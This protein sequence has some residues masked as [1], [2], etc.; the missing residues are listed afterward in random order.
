MCLE[1]CRDCILENSSFAVLYFWN[2]GHSNQRLSIP[3]GREVGTCGHWPGNETLLSSREMY[4]SWTFA[5]MVIAY[6]LYD[7]VEL[8]RSKQI[9]VRILHCCAAFSC[10]FS[11]ILLGSCGTPVNKRRHSAKKLADFPWSTLWN[12]PELSEK[13][14]SWTLQTPPLNLRCKEDPPHDPTFG[15]LKHLQALPSRSFLLLI[16]IL[17]DFRCRD[18]LFW[19][20]WDSIRAHTGLPTNSRNLPIQCQD[21][22]KALPNCFQKRTHCKV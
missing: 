22:S 18:G 16:L 14:A 12:F 10:S 2:Q 13:R 20:I 11:S 9:K 4:Q 19:P 21:S 5:L 8:S 7:M 1:S 17:L 15:G 3:F 6:R